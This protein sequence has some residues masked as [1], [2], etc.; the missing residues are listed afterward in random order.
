[1]CSFVATT[2]CRR[3]G[4]SNTPR[5]RLDTA[6][7]L[8]RVRDASLVRY[9]RDQWHARCRPPINWRF[10]G[11]TLIR[12]R[13]GLT[14]SGR[15]SINGVS[16]ILKFPETKHP[17]CVERRQQQDLSFSETL[18]RNFTLIKNEKEFLHPITRPPQ[19][20][21]RCSPAIAARRRVL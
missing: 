13:N 19:S 7:R 6:R 4:W 21:A 3:A 20:V 15:L 5:K 16:C 1:M 17:W 9:Y 2:L 12:F 14:K 18:L 8:L 11:T 10:K